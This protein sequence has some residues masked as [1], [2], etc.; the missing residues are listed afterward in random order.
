MFKKIGLTFIILLCIGVVIYGYMNE[1]KSLMI[2]FTAFAFIT[3][4]LWHE[5]ET[6]KKILDENDRRKPCPISSLEEQPY[7]VYWWKNIDGSYWAIFIPLI[8]E[9]ENPDPNKYY[10]RII[11]L[12]HERPR[13]K[14][15]IPILS[16]DKMEILYFD[17][18]SENE[19]EKTPYGEKIKSQPHIHDEF[20]G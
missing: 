15:V 16:N 1:T 3:V 20:G 8:G 11:K 17:D 9:E 5:K 18:F 14:Y 10:P 7:R 2:G 19:V 4:C 6:V 13:S 12:R